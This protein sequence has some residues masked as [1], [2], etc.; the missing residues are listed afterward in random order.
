MR[1]QSF[2]ILQNIGIVAIAGIS[3]IDDVYRANNLVR[4]QISGLLP[5]FIPVARD[6]GC[7]GGVHE[8]ACYLIDR[9]AECLVM[10]QYRLPAGLQCI[11][12]K[13]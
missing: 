5:D 10:G 11:S 1:P 8:M 2:R 13:R 6:A 3:A 7:E 4:G 9:A 12:S